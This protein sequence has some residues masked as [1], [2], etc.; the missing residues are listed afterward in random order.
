[1][2][3]DKDFHIVTYED[4][5]PR[6][7]D[8]KNYVI[9]EIHNVKS[10]GAGHARFCTDCMPEYQARMISEGRCDNPWIIFRIMGS[11][12]D[13]GIA[14]CIPKNI[15]SLVR[16]GE[17]PEFFIDQEVEVLDRKHGLNRK[18]IRFLTDEK[19]GS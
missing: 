11:G 17:I 16:Q 7:T 4:G 2:G 5:I 8:K 10:S 12:K 13:A 3:Y 18:R 1:M 6:C 15:K 9:W 19:K 14:G